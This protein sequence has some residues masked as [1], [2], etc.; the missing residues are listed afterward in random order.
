MEHFLIRISSLKYSY[1]DE[2]STIFGEN[3]YGNDMTE[4]GLISND[5][6]FTIDG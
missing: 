4:I 1:R 3:A 6:D 2:S 5:Q